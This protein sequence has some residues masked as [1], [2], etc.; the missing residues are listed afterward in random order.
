MIEYDIAEATKCKDPFF[1]FVH[2]CLNIRVAFRCDTLIDSESRSAHRYLPAYSLYFI[3]PGLPNNLKD[4]A[5]ES[6]F[7][8]F[9]I[10]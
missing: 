2:G 6:G 3:C 4:T 10:F 9:S 1:D 5:S 8:F 7:L